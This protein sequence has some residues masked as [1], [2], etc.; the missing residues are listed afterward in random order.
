MSSTLVFNSQSK[1]PIHRS[2][3]DVLDRAFAIRSCQYRG[4][5]PDWSGRDSFEPSADAG[6]GRQAKCKRPNG[7]TFDSKRRRAES[8]YGRS[9]VRGNPAATNADQSKGSTTTMARIDRSTR[10]SSLRLW[11]GIAIVVVQ[12][13]ARFVVPAFV[14]EAGL[15]GAMAG[16]LGGVAI[17]VW[18]LFLSRAPW[19]ERVGALVLMGIALAATPLILHESIRT[20]AMGMLFFLYAVPVV[21]LALVAWAVVSRRFEAAPRRAL[22]VVAIALSCGMWALVQTA[23]FDGAGD[24][25]FSWRWAK[26]AEDRLDRKS[27]V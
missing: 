24:S 11:P 14:P 13:V 10:E 22:L 9:I 4:I 3:L 6:S 2:R 21:S 23:G 19:T 12:W 18:W 27:V 1:E 7:E 8:A 17:V 15:V 25:D 20:G 5:D 16:F 26:T